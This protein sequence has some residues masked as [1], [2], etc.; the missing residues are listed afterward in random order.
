MGGNSSRG[1]GTIAYVW[2]VT[3]GADAEDSS[4]LTQQQLAKLFDDLAHEETFRAY[5][6][7]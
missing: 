5:R 1:E 3:G 7:L 2:D 4:K 6:A